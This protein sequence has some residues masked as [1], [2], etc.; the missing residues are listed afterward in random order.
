MNKNIIDWPT[1][2]GALLLLIIIAGPLIIVPE[3][4]EEIVTA[5]STAPLFFSEIRCLT[6]SVC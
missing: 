1:F 2:I 6:A 5:S 3:F 4:G